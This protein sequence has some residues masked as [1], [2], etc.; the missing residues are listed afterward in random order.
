MAA[1][2]S[3][4]CAGRERDAG[5]AKAKRRS[6]PMKELF[7]AGLDKTG[8]IFAPKKEGQRGS[9][10][11]EERA[12]EPETAPGG[13]SCLLSASR[14]VEAISRSRGIFWKRFLW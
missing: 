12:A 4:S 9:G 2:G 5:V 14:P 8:G 11:G 3:T 13:L 6:L 1:A 10:A 7:R